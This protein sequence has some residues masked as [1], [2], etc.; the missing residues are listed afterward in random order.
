MNYMNFKISLYNAA[1]VDRVLLSNIF[2]V[3]LI[4]TWS[5]NT[6]ALCE[7]KSMQVYY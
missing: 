2:E 6:E 1:P 5:S 7:K 4:I 3:L